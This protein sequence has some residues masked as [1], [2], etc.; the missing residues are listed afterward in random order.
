M[1]HFV[2]DKSK[3]YALVQQTLLDVVR[4]HLPP[5]QWTASV[6][7]RRENA[8]N[9]SLFV[10]QPAD[11][12]MSHG[13]AD[14]NYFTDVWDTDG[15]LFA[16]R[17]SAL[18]VPGPWL[19]RKLLAF[20]AFALTEDRI[21]SVGWPRL[22]LL[23]EMNAAATRSKLIAPSARTRVLWAPTHDFAKR[24]D[25][26]LSTS[27]YPA[28]QECLPELEREFDV[29]VSLHPRNRSDKSPTDSA[30]IKADVVISDFGTLVYEAWALG[31]PVIFPRWLLGDRIQKYLPG[32]AEAH[33]FDNE[34]GYHPRSLDELV[35]I[36]RAKPAISPEVDAFMHDYLD[37]YQTGCAGA[38][39][40][41][42]LTALDAEMR[43][44]PN[45]PRTA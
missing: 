36:V 25:E 16:N 9:F 6:G 42:V 15:K 3:N 14:K 26:Q 35:A 22:D 10:R 7:K 5:G 1:I 4:R 17:L 27:S 11:V 31:K 24:G 13:V 30:L 41:T 23:R 38:R 39:I 18:L 19:K 43:G 21:H 29:E 45:L 28:F 34:I 20:P 33:I 40:A 37:N 12:V 2:L 8:L 44:R 32:S